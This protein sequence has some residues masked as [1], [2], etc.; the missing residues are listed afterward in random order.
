M[1]R[2][3]SGKAYL[4]G[5]GI[6]SLS[7]ACFLIRDAHMDPKQIYIFEESPIL[8]GS[9]DGGGSAE[10][11]YVIRGGRMMNFTYLCT[12]DI[13]SWVPSLN[14]PQKSVFDEINNFNREF[15][16]DAHARLLD[17][18]SH[19]LDSS[20]MGFSNRD[21]L[22][23][24]TIMI[25]NEDSLGLKTIADCFEADFFATPFWFMWATMFA[26]QPWHSAVEFK[27]YL[28]RF[29]HEFPRISSLAGVDRTPLNQYDS[30]IRPIE[31]HLKNLGVNFEAHSQI[32]DV[33]FETELGNSDGNLLSN[34]E[35]TQKLVK[36]FH[37]VT[38]QKEMDIDVLD[39]DKVFITLGSM[40]ACSSLGSHNEAPHALKKEDSGSWK[41]W[42]KIA[43]G[44]P[45]FGRPNVFCDRVLESQWESF[46][47][48]MKDSLLLNLIE[49]KTL[50]S[51]GTGALM[52]FKDSNWLMSIVVARQ[53]HFA[54][55]PEN[56]KVL[57]GYGLFPN[58]I[59]NFVAK[60]M[61]EC[62]GQEILIELLGHLG[63]Q[64]VQNQVLETSI[65]IPC[66][67]PFITSQ[68]L[69]RARG[70]RPRVR[71]HNYPNLALLGQFCEVA[72]D[73]VFTV[74]YS[75][76][77]A[78]MGVYDLFGLDKKIPQVYKGEYDPGVLFQ[79][80][81]ASLT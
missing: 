38:H 48:T 11:A 20:H 81:K 67:M 26:F 78:Q 16:T 13:L 33:E 37:L 73:V 32:T 74:E 4:I 68:F 28:H 44:R 36:R 42:E 34:Y 62:S 53:P 46:T 77:T 60:P 41:L 47:L 66:L 57:W 3:N 56:I 76:R 45:E 71:P 63:M 79:A 52:S 18:N 23:L 59:G 12:Y 8:G 31:S 27:R 80:L 9:L 22:D 21:R 10:T 29:I 25:K 24:V 39:E 49:E 30:I 2:S 61:I 14:S 6:A 72:D 40:T 64:S 7:A 50:N 5:G 69:T 70:D 19:I 15:K 54:N 55:Q 51:P 43:K 17:I 1:A 75:V 58:R 65:C 35:Y